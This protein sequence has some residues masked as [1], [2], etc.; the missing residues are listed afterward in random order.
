[1]MFGES[2]TKQT[3]LTVEA[4]EEQAVRDSTASDVDST[5]EERRPRR[6]LGCVIAVPLLV[7][8]VLFMPLL[9]TPVF[10]RLGWQPP[11]PITYALKPIRAGLGLKDRRLAYQSET[12]Q[13]SFDEGALE[14]GTED[15]LS[16][17]VTSTMPNLS[18]TPLPYCL[19][20][21][22]KQQRCLVSSS[23]PHLETAMHSYPCR[24]ADTVFCAMRWEARTTKWNLPVYICGQGIDTNTCFSQLKQ[25][26]GNVALAGRD[27]LLAG[28]VS[29]VTMSPTFCIEFNPK[30]QKCL[31]TSDDRS[32]STFMASYPCY[33]RDKV[34]CAGDWVARTTKWNLPVTI[35][36]LGMDINTCFSQLRQAS[37]RQL[38]A[39]E[40]TPQDLAA[41]RSTS[42]SSSVTHTTYT[43]TISKQ[44]DEVC[45]RCYKDIAA[46][47]TWQYMKCKGT[48]SLAI[49][50]F[51]FVAFLEN[52]AIVALFIA[53]AVAARADPVAEMLT[54]PCLFSIAYIVD[55]LRWVV[56]TGV[57]IWATLVSIADVLNCTVNIKYNCF[58][59]S[60]LMTLW[61][62]FGAASSFILGVLCIADFFIMLC[63]APWTICGW[64]NWTGRKGEMR[65]ARLVYF[66]LCVGCVVFSYWLAYI[67]AS[68][69]PC[70][71]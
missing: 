65:R 68:A 62:W 12:T 43:T 24:L 35:C 55:I 60:N 42:T 17:V 14:L 34:A 69:A 11:R 64:E 45:A 10:H 54:E 71:Y 41:K 3:L 36:G 1:M 44:P 20:F 67:W 23:D 2:N 13:P 8:G 19:E 49:N 50:T 25:G 52:L 66:F 40:T 70:P 9:I 4:M 59:V 58:F 22:P 48:P 16:G 37:Y 56:V 51:C 31:V 7:L 47:G 29:T 46:C 57:T 27:T 30:H 21:A 26:P 15:L 38:R 63:T 39:L 32:L 5:Q 18:A 28:G 53:G 61:F 6:F 33:S